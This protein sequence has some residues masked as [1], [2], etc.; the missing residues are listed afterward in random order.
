MDGR[1]TAVLPWALVEFESGRLATGDVEMRWE[2]V[3]TSDPVLE[4]FYVFRQNMISS[5][6]PLEGIWVTAQD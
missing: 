1:D 4:E 5:V 6:A 3:Y 2:R